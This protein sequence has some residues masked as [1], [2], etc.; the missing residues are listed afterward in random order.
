[1]W[2]L[3]DAV[4]SGEGLMMHYKKE[5]KQEGEDACRRDKTR[6]AVPLHD[7]LLSW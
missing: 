1:L 7:N 5:G 6:E 2:S 4:A 3:E